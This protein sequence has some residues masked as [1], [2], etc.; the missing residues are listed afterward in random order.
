M[1]KFPFPEKSSS[2]QLNVSPQKCGADDISKSETEE[3]LPSD[4]RSRSVGSAADAA[5]A[6]SGAS[7]ASAASATSA[8]SAASA[9][10]FPL[11][12][13]APSLPLPDGATLESAPASCYQLQPHQ[14]HHSPSATSPSLDKPTT[15]GR[16][17]PLTSPHTETVRL[18]SPY[19]PP[20]CYEDIPTLA[21]T[22]VSDHRRKSRSS[23][24]SEFDC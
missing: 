20:S 10:S 22:L 1:S 19:S 23:Q 18:T 12:D 13:A 4:Q 11:D 6:V 9:A 5:S 24:D 21:S 17:D 2:L 8:A 7:A 14:P 3:S 16:L 15:P